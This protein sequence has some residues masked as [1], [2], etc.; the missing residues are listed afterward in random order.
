MNLSYC[1]D[2]AEVT[3]RYDNSIRTRR[4]AHGKLVDEGFPLS[5]VSEHLADPEALVW[6]DL[7]NPE[8]AALLELA[9][10]W[11][12]D[13]HAVE[14]SLAHGER[15]K[16]TR[17]ATHTFLTI[18]ATHLFPD[19]EDE[20]RRTSPGSAPRGSPPSS[21]PAASSPF[22]A[23]LPSTST[24]WCAGGTRTPTCCSTGRVR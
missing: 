2:P 5:T 10:E 11:N 3:D 4:W 18:Y 24:K 9:E 13:P 8:H 19:S 22:V 12:L 14:D 1:G 17:Y 7:W 16:A 6:V 20:I 21:C 15:T 23:A